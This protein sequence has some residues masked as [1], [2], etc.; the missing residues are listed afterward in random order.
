MHDQEKL[1]SVLKKKMVKTIVCSRPLQP[2]HLQAMLTVIGNINVYP[3]LSLQM[4]TVGPMEH[5][6]PL[7]TLETAGPMETL[8]SRFEAS[9]I[10]RARITYLIQITG[11]T[12]RNKRKQSKIMYQTI[13]Q[14]ENGNTEVVFDKDF[15]EEEFQLDKVI[16]CKDIE[17]KFPEFKVDLRQKSKS[18]IDTGV[19]IQLSFITFGNE[20]GLCF[21]WEK[22]WLLERVQTWPLFSIDLPEGNVGPS[23]PFFR[24]TELMGRAV[25]N[26][27]N[28]Y[29]EGR[30]PF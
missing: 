24:V 29:G 12:V 13:Y 9:N 28:F 4:R 15:T 8:C 16:N 2:E 25:Y 10:M 6:V 18:T 23:H 5:L 17:D 21:K 27:L 3:P 19:I 1:R 26:Y 14:V 7:L 30:H 22:G 20:S 11:M